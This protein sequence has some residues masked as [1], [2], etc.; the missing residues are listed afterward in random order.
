M[1]NRLKTYLTSLEDAMYHMHES[2]QSWS[3]EYTA[4]WRESLIIKRTIRKLERLEK[5][6][7]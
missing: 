4:L 7:R 2:D 3:R 1:I 6:Y 5:Y